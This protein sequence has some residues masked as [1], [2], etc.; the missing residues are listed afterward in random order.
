MNRGPGGARHPSPLWPKLLCSGLA[1]VLLL[2]TGGALASE[3]RSTGPDMAAPGALPSA[4]PSPGAVLGFDP[5]ALRSLTGVTPVTGSSPLLVGLSLYPRDPAALTQFVDQVSTPGTAQFGHYLTPE[6]FA[7]RF[8]PSPGT[9][10]RVEATLRDAGF[11][12]VHAY[13]DRLFLTAEGTAQAAESLFSTRLVSGIGPNGAEMLPATPPV[14]P[15]ALRSVVQ[16]VTGLSSGDQ[17][18]S[19]PFSPLAGSAG[20]SQGG[21]SPITPND[22]HTLYGLDSLY[23]VSTPPRYANGTGIGILLWGDGFSPQDIA[24]FEQQF[25]PGNEPPFN[26]TAVPM[27]GAP[28]PSA[29]AVNDPS[30]APFEL[31][32]DMEWAGSAAPGSHLEVVYVPDGP[33]PSYSPSTTELLDGLSFLVNVANVSVITQS[34]G[35]PDSTGTSYQGTADTLYEQAAAEGITV[36]AASGDDGG[37]GGSLSNTC[38]GTVD[39]MYPASSPWVTGVGGTD[40]SLNALGALASEVAWSHS[41]GGFSSAYSTP[42]WQQTGSAYQEIQQFGP[43]RRGV[44]DVA[45]P[46]A[47][48]LLYYDGSP[49]Q[50]QGTS[51]AAPMW[52]GMVAEM[53]ALAGHRLGFLNPRLYA[54]GTAQ[55]SGFSPAPFREINQGANC[56]YSAGPGPGWDPVTGWGVPANALTLFGDLTNRFASIGMAFTPGTGEPGASFTVSLTVMNGS[57]PL[58]NVPVNVTFLSYPTTASSTSPL[59]TV[60]VTTN[61]TGQGAAAFRV[62]LSYLFDRLLVEA[63]IFT[64]SEVGTNSSVI[65]ISLLGGYLSFLA[66]YMTYPD[67]VVL[68]VLIMA[69]ATALGWALGVRRRPRSPPQSSAARTGPAGQDAGTSTSPG[70]R[71]VTSVH[72][73]DAPPG[74]GG[75]AG[76]GSISSGPPPTGQVEASSLGVPLGGGPA[77]DRADAPSGAQAGPAPSPA[78]VREA[79]STQTPTDPSTLP[80]RPS[81][82]GA[83][84]D[85]TPAETGGGDESPPLPAPFPCWSCGR[86]VPGDIEACPFCGASLR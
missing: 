21:S 55:G 10:S 44:P 66:P 37:Q 61:A 23:N 47:D 80:S 46:A 14:L 9:L 58:V 24:T 39:T 56:V 30:H 20:P 26:Y 36:F 59:K 40:P 17:I 77:A 53:D 33:A 2:A 54:L 31:T 38:Q 63:Q 1:F 43:G 86:V 42:P 79:P 19:L 85:G 82:L 16:F 48:D 8:S 67:N 52:G 11:S 4:G 69:G 78:A 73:S 35:S 18:F 65:D 84:G 81:E 75:V 45:G 13:P 7:E 22:V 6:A 74:P 5:G 76:P 3:P 70:D 57:R 25:Y 64:H 72:A 27:D 83:A 50:G 28:A 60:E 68:F 12:V 41:G 62:P 15:P 34:F 71:S 49:Q 32:L 51:F 29:G